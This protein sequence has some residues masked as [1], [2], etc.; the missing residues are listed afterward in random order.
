MTDA[1]V[2]PSHQPESERILEELG[3]VRDSRNP[4][5]HLLEQLL[6]ASGAV[7]MKHHQKLILAQPKS[8]IMVHFPV[9][10]DNG[11]HRLFK[12]YRVQHNNALGPFKGGLRFHP[13]VSLDETKALA[14]LTTLKCSLLRLPFG[15]AMGGVKCNVGEMS[16][17]ELMRLTRR[18]AS[19]LS[20]YVG[21]DYDVVEPDVG[22]DGRTMAWFADTLVQ[23]TADVRRQEMIRAVTGKPVEMGGSFGRDRA[24]GQ[25]LVDVLAEML[26][27]VGVEFN[28]GRFVSIGFGTVG[29]WAARKLSE[30]GMTLVAALDHT[31]AIWNETGIDPFLLQEYVTRKGGIEGFPAAT[32][33]PERDVWTVNA[34][35]LVAAASDGLID[36]DRAA[37]VSARVVVE[38]G[39]IPVTPDG[40]DVLLA[41][42]IEILPSVL[43]GAGGVV[44]SYLEWVQNRL[45]TTWSGEEVDEELRR[46]MTLAARRVKL[47]RIRYECDW[48]SAALCASCERL[49]RVYD[50]RGVFP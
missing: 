39:H 19:S 43:C 12:G 18:F 35:V 29:A 17:G 26:P 33:V 27:E 22:T 42:G 31:G 20:H 38:G 41:R 9:L 15:G 45:S 49:G 2:R 40:A 50:L 3:I 37:R 44:A 4:F 34:D 6:D 5:H 25:G 23:T 32:S 1:S 7:G 36:G 14:V 13:R 8:E 30:R 11:H 46:A 48:R 28:G 24:V 21:P 16:Q 47:A 10:M